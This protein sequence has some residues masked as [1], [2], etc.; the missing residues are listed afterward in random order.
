MHYLTCMF[1]MASIACKSMS[2]LFNMIL[3]NTLALS[4]NLMCLAP[5]AGDNQ[6]CSARATAAAVRVRAS[7]RPPAKNCARILSPR[8]RLL[9]AV[10]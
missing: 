10:G 1:L 4:E 5:D 9:G 2:V 8:Q 3:H 6:L 7:V